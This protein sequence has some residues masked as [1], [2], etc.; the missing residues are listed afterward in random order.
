MTWKKLNSKV[1]YKNRYMTVMEEVFLTDH[2]DKVVYG[3]VHK[4]P[5]SVV[6]AW[7]TERVLL[8]GQYRPSAE[9]FSWEFP[10]GH[11]ETDDPLVAA[12]RELK[13]ETGLLASDLVEIA[14]C[15]PAIGTM[16]Q[17]CY[18]YV[19][20]HWVSGQKNLDTSEKDMQQ[21]WVTLK[22]LEQLIYDGTIIDGPTITALKYF[23]HYLTKHP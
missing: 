20:R 21:K 9:I 23:E 7:D 18:I 17:K 22:E 3:I 12:K 13:E 19:A 8:V 2:G 4:D 6:I 16:D 14:T 11:A 5:F 15:Y 1:V 10:M